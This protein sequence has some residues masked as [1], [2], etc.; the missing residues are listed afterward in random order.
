MEFIGETKVPEGEFEKRTV[1]KGYNNFQIKIS[2]LINPLFK[3]KFNP[4]GLPAVPIPKLNGFG[5]D[6]LPKMLLTNKFFENIGSE[7][8][9]PNKLRE[10][11]NKI[12]ADE[13]N[14]YI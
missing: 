5:F 1:N 6:F 14:K 7:F 8:I 11:I 13:R 3:S 12:Y 4:K 9:M 2:R 10:R